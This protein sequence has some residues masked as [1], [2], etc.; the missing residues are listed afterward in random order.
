MILNANY[1]KSRVMSSGPFSHDA[2]L[3]AFIHL[4]SQHATIQFPRNHNGTLPLLLHWNIIHIQ[5]LYIS[6]TLAR[7]SSAW[8]LCLQNRTALLEW[9]RVTGSPKTNT[10]TNTVRTTKAWRNHLAAKRATPK[11]QLSSEKPEPSSKEFKVLPPFWDLA[12]SNELEKIR[13]R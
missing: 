11:S 13:P 1:S 6:C 2:A 12:G 5:A 3:I 7:S 8:F 4:I 10:R 9:G